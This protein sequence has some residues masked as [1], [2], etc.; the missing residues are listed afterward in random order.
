MHSKTSRIRLVRAAALLAALLLLIGCLASPNP[1][2]PRVLAPGDYTPLRRYLTAFIQREM[3]RSDIV[4]LS[5]A[6]VDD[7]ETVWSQG[8]GYADRE[9]GRRATADTV[10]RVGSISKLFTATA[11]MQLAERGRLDIDQPLQGVLPEF[12][13]R[14]RFPDAPPITVRSL[15]T[16]HSGLPSNLLKGELIEYPPPPDA[17]HRYRGLPAG[18]RDTWLIHPPQRVWAYSNLGYALLG[19]VV[20]RA[21]GRD[22][23][24]YIEEEILSPLGMSRSSFVEKT[25]RR[26]Q[27]ARPYVRGRAV[28][29]YGIRDLPAGSMLS[30]AND[31]ARFM[32]AIAAGGTA[33]SA[34]ILET[35]TLR[36][37]LTPQN[38]NVALDVDFRIGLGWWL[39]NPLD[40]PGIRMASHG[41]DI[42]PFHSL[43]VTLPD[44]K[45]GVAVLTNSEEGAA[46]I[47]RIATE[48]VLLAVDIKQGIRPDRE[49]NPVIRPDREMLRAHTGLYASPM[50]LIRVDLRRGRLAATVFDRRFFLDPRQDGSFSLDHPLL[51]VR[52][53]LFSHLLQRIQALE[54]TTIT[55]HEID[56]SRL[57]ALRPGGVFMGIAERI[58]PVP[59]PPAWRERVGRYRILNP[60]PR[61]VVETL[62]L[63][64][65]RKTDL[66][67]MEIEV[68]DQRMSFPLHPLSDRLAVID[69]EGRNLGETVEIVLDGG[70]ERLVYSGYRA[71][72]IR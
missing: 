47:F 53:R 14:S 51:G 40:L 41:G 20:E 49:A 50:G 10:Y 56:G 67:L 17:V 68:F 12:S 5:I 33:G 38:E 2:R 63:E 39:I 66:L 69:G 71:G 59:V 28:E 26:N 29:P 15:L 70:E 55:S 23:I 3:R 8:F 65:E 18:L 31:L 21:S 46:A 61:S 58:E 42:P 27:P 24:R 22:F 6:V 48:A 52:S 9:N 35:G 43:L 64:Y 62:R 36:L 72:K 32:K 25:G 7:Q 44:Q 60:D 54:S 19:S 37:M 13:V 57:V 11:V 34:R 16:H 4:G 45:L 1:A 30:S